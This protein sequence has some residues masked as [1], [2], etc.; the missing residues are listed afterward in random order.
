M[1]AILEMVQQILAYFNEMDAA[2]VVEIVKN[3]IES[4]IAGIPMPL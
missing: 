3:T 2:N 1:T 4:I